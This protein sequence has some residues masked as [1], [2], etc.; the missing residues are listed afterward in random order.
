MKFEN[1]LNK[2][3]KDLAT[4]G[5][6][7]VYKEKEVLLGYKKKLEQTKIDKNPRGY[8]KK[9]LL[10]E[11]DSDDDYIESLEEEEKISP[12]LEKPKQRCLQRD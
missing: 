3:C 1:L 7:L 9:A 11:T 10:E 5:N 2:K 12:I 6:S 4:L 8:E